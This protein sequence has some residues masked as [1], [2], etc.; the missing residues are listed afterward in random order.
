MAE[1]SCLLTNLVTEIWC[2]YL[3]LRVRKLLGGVKGLCFFLTL[4]EWRMP[5][6]GFILRGV[7][8]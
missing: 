4:G 8:G 5:E 6:L 2:T 3:S 1:F 7:M